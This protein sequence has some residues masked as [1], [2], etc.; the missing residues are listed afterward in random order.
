MLDPRGE[1]TTAVCL[2]EG[3]I[4]R[5]V[6]QRSRSRRDKRFTLD[7][8]VLDWIEAESSRRGESQSA[9]VQ[10]ALRAAMA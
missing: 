9:V 8:D 3:R 6:S 4:R 10:D 5:D 2:W 7:S 1:P